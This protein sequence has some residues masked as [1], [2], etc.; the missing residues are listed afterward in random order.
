MG[1]L[2][3]TAYVS[4]APG[5]LVPGLRGSAVPWGVIVENSDA[6]Y[7][8]YLPDILS[9]GVTIDVESASFVDVLEWWLPANYDNTPFAVDLWWRGDTGETATARLTVSDGSNSDSAEITSS[10]NVLAKGSLTVTP[11]SSSASATPRKATLAL[12][13]TGTNKTV[14]VDHV[15]SFYGQP[16]SLPTGV[17]PSGWASLNGWD[18]D[19]AGDGGA[20]ASEPTVRAAN[21]ARAV[22][23]DRPA[24]LVGFLDDIRTTGARNTTSLASWELF[25][26]WLQP[27]S[28][29]GP[30]R[31]RFVVNLN[32]T[33]TA[34]PA[35]LITL[36][37]YQH[38]VSGVGVH[39]FTADLALGS[40]IQGTAHVKVDSG[41]G[42]AY[43]PTLQILR[44]RE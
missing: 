10:T 8:G 12:K 22:A 33:S 38:E 26:R 17:Q 35:A 5:A 16:S 19:G 34:V 20:Q 31:Y 44:E 29:V 40:G 4:N 27:F 37:N 42:N 15:L 28:D 43:L 11:S 39:H 14:S 24:G 18:L 13:I 36:G 1:A 30:R 6:A 3:A 7:D 2:M 23:R 9:S 32:R 41:S 25:H 21:N